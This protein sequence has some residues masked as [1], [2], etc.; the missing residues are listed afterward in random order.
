MI[1]KNSSHQSVGS[2]S[3]DP[4]IPSAAPSGVRVRPSGP[5]ETDPDLDADDGDEDEAPEGSFFGVD[6]EA[7]KNRIWSIFAKRQRALGLG[8]DLSAAHSKRFPP[9]ERSGAARKVA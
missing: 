9:K 8:A 6:D 7:A 4:V 3:V 2:V 5:G 1:A